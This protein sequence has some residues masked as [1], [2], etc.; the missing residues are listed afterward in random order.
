MRLGL[1][2]VKRRAPLWRVFVE[3]PT[4]QLAPKV[5]H[6][7]PPPSDSADGAQVAIVYVKVK[8]TA[9]GFDAI[10]LCKVR[11]R[12][13]AAAAAR[14]HTHTH[15]HTHTCS[16]AHKHVYVR[17]HK[18]IKNAQATRARVRACTRTHVQRHTYARTHTHTRAT[19]TRARASAGRSGHA[20]ATEG[21][22]CTSC[23][24]R[25]TRAPCNVPPGD[26]AHHAT[27]LMRRE[28]K[29]TAAPTH[30]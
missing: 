14:T 30:H 1:R 2:P 12:T 29:Q 8:G 23:P 19:H 10:K 28:D 3:F 17:A 22:L 21:A 7:Q 15:T 6:S 4:G 27:A 13:H 11:L 26:G 9:A 20:S 5:G 25:P 24:R 16:H 18:L